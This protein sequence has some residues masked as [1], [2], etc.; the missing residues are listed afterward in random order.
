MLRDQAELAEALL[1]LDGTRDAYAARYAAFR[2]RHC[3]LED[4]Q[5][6]GRVVQAL[7]TAAGTR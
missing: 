7:L 2:A 4:G 6:T 3:A 1:D 5:A